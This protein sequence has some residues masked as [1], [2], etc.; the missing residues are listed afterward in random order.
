MWYYFTFGF[1]KFVAANNIIVDFRDWY[2]FLSKTR[3][4]NEC[5][6]AQV[7]PQENKL[8]H[9]NLGVRVHKE[10]KLCWLPEALLVCTE[11]LAVACSTPSAKFARRVIW[12]CVTTVKKTKMNFSRLNWLYLKKI[13]VLRS[14]QQQVAFYLAWKVARHIKL[15]I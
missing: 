7:Y 4:D 3:Q 13:T 11:D 2:P 12:L 15:L 6:Q 10:K 8:E 1:H 14:Q 5:R 9:L